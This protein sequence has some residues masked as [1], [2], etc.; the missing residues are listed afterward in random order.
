MTGTVR[1]DIKPGM[2]VR[3]VLKDDNPIVMP[4]HR[5]YSDSLFP[6]GI[7]ASFAVA[8]LAGIAAGVSSGLT[9]IY[10]ND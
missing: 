6:W 4:M 2:E 5:K 3:I 8:L 7:G 10:K 1:A 9:D